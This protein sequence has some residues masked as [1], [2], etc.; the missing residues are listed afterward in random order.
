MISQEELRKLQLLELQMLKD[1]AAVCDRNNL[2]Y[3]LCCG[4]LL[5]AVRHQGFI[6]WDD[7]VD[8]AMP[9]EDYKRF[10]RIGQEQLGDPY[11]LQSC[12]T[13]ILFHR[14]YTR[15]RANHTT[16]LKPMHKKCKTHQGV[17]IDIF[18]FVYFDSMKELARK[19]KIIKFSNFLQIDD[20]LSANIGEYKRLL[21]KKGM[22]LVR[23]LF[24]VP[25]KTRQRMHIKILDWLGKKKSGKYCA[26][27]WGN[28]THAYTNDIVAGEKT[29]LLFEDSYFSVF[30]NYISYLEQ[31][32]G[33]Y[34]TPP[35][36]EERTGHGEGMIVD[37]EHDYAEYM[38]WGESRI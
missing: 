35:P 27:I 7:D 37:L 34:M 28:I 1:M 19:Q 26:I 23:I 17:W 5:G 11:F 16:M 6:P 36:V 15:I 22:A 30:P 25:I 24:K 13:D 4:T 14:A 9:Y 21:G 31:G 8:V 20:F 10:L 38:D 33:D 18:P 12:E 3:Y 2:T 29:K 32:Y